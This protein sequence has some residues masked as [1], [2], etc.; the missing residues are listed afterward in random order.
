[1]GSMA[2]SPAEG[3]FY[4][5]LRFSSDCSARF[6]MKAWR[7]FPRAHGI[8]TSVF[9]AV[10]MTDLIKRLFIFCSLNCSLVSVPGI[11]LLLIIKLSDQSGGF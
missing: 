9:S 5:C 2:H 6:W 7:R 4:A 8:S 3:E 11:C 1:M 10:A